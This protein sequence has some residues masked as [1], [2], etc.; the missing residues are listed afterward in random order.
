MSE[1]YKVRNPEGLYFIT[2]T[3]INC[4]DLFT[5][6]VY[7]HIII[8]SLEH[9]IHNKELVIYAYVIMSNHIHLIVSSGENFRLANTIRDFKKFTAKKF[10]TAINEYPESRREW[11]LKKFAFAAN[12]IKRGQNYKI[13]KDGFHPIELTTREI[14][15]QKLN[16]IHENPVTEELVV[17]EEDYKY[18][19]AIN[20][21]GGIGH[22]PIVLVK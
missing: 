16:Y 21:A 6:P 1:K 7:K 10:I 22:L 12:R 5:R 14:L 11:L 20:Y 18:S 9:C 17:N 2:C 19:S 8:E 13:W 3:T 4:V 15:E